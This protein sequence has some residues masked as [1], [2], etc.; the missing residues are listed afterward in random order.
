MSKI[1]VLVR[2]KI[3]LGNYESADIEIKVTE[4]T[5]PNEKTSDGIDRVY[6][7]VASKVAEKAKRI[8]DATKSQQ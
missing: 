4:D 1:E 6:D 7:L 2:T 5:F 3:N 8:A